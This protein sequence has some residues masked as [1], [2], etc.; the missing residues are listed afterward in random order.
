MSTVQQPEI[1]VVGGGVAGLTATAVLADAGWHV[2]CVDQVPETVGATDNRTTAFLG[3]AVDLL[4][5]CGVWQRLAADI[6]PLATMRLID[7]GGQQN[8]AR[9]IADFKAAEIAPDSAGFG[10]NVPNIAIRAAL[11]DRIA[12]QAG[13]TLK[14]DTGL[15]ALTARRDH[16]RVRLTD[17]TCLTPHL[18]I[19]A[20]GRDSAV[21]DLA[22]IGTRR[23][24]YE[25]KAL[26]FSV[27]H[28]AP[29]LG[30]S[31]EIHR[32]GGP[33]TLVPMPDRDGAHRSS[34]VWMEHAGEAVRLA[35]LH[36]AAFIAEMNERSLGVLGRLSAPSPRTPWPMM[37]LIAERL[38]APRVALIAEAAHVVPP[39]GAQGLNMSLGDI[40]TLRD[41]IAGGDPGRAE[42]LRAYQRRWPELRARVTAIDALNRAAMT[43]AQP[44][45]DLRRAGLSLIA[46]APAIRRTAM[47]LGLGVSAG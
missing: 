16:V 15:D 45:R 10:W 24:R 32:T 18:V 37:A 20:D 25:Q 14:H 8:E 19:G 47:R 36:E 2:L 9:E 13:A 4:S 17:G 1:L 12:E 34:V 22:G 26:V 27:T 33:F 30:V 31:T 3:P 43:S 23:W 7:A 44:L 21:R 28:E 11:R 35:G 42:A 46:T 38:T 39:I 41:R 6:A 5:E 29:H 40:A